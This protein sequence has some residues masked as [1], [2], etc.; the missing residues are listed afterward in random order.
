MY[1][2]VSKLHDP[3][4]HTLHIHVRMY[5]AYN[6]LTHTHTHTLS[7]TSVPYSQ[8]EAQ[9]APPSPTTGHTPSPFTSLTPTQPNSRL[10]IKQLVAEALYIARPLVHSESCMNKLLLNGRVCSAAVNTDIK[11]NNI[12]D[13]HAKSKLS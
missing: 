10:T 9:L 3:T 4:K 5:C 8:L 1:C 11:F 6:I 13:L 12:N 2:L 7:D